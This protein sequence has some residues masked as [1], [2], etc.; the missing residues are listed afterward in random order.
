MYWFPFFNAN[1]IVIKKTEVLNKVKFKKKMLKLLWPLLMLNSRILG[2][3]W[4]GTA[5]F[6][7][8]LV[9]LDGD[10]DRRARATHYWRQIRRP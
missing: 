6:V 7:Q 9:I 5:Y 3:I 4:R 2:L 1:M 8:N 10:S